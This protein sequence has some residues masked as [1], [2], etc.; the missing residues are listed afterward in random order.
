MVDLTDVKE[1]TIAHYDRMIKYAKSKWFGVFRKVDQSDMEFDINES[2]FGPDCPYCRAFKGRLVNRKSKIKCPL[3]ND[4]ATTECG[5][6]CCGGRWETMASAKTWKE[7][8]R[9]A[10]D[11]VEY[12]RRNG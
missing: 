11:V 10:E 12:I 6:E 3:S 1:E 9:R 7:W 2:W 4:F 8:V 5:G